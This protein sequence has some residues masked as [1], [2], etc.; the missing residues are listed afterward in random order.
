MT[1]AISGNPS[2]DQF[3]RIHRSPQR[4]PFYVENCSAL[5]FAPGF[6]E[7]IRDSRTPP[8]KHRWIVDLPIARR[9]SFNETFRQERRRL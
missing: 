2:R 1:T 6:R 3:A 5:N 7:P 4:E 8:R 9:G